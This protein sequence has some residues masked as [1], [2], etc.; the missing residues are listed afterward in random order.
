[1]DVRCDSFRK[2][3]TRVDVITERHGSSLEQILVEKHI[4]TL[5]IML[6]LVFFLNYYSVAQQLNLKKN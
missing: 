3:R 1:L 2:F 6:L 5:S 4:N